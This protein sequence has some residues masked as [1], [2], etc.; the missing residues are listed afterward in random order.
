[1]YRVKRRIPETIG[2]SN[3]I[4]GVQDTDP[5]FDGEGESHMGTPGWESLTCNRVP[6]PA[7]CILYQFIRAGSVGANWY[8]VYPLYSF[9][10]LLYTQS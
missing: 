4:L 9:F 10:L 5:Q 2:D 7:H 3:I 1:M 8:C 6:A